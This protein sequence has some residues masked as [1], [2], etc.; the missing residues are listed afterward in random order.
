MINLICFLHILTIQHGDLYMMDQAAIQ[1]VLVSLFPAVSTVMFN[2][3][4]QFIMPV[5]FG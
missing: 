5:T 4:K 2:L 1:E 3:S